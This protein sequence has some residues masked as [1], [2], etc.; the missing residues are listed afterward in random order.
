M[1]IDPAWQNKGLIKFVADMLIK[2]LENHDIPFTYGYPNKKSYDLHINLLDYED[3]AVQ[4]LFFKLLNNAG[5]ALNQLGF[6]RWKKIE[7]FDNRVNELWDSIKNN[8]QNCVIRNSAFLNWRYLDR[9]DIPYFAYG[10][11]NG[12][13]LDGYYVL[14]IY[15]IKMCYEDISLIYLLRTRIVIVADFLLIMD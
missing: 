9:T 12:E 8:F 3:V 11:F 13:K 2:E 7:R 14:K 5:N 1:M 4:R 10:A 15:Q 6:L